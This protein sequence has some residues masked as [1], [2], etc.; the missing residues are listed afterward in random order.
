MCLQCTCDCEG[1][2]PGVVV[3]NVV[4]QLR[5]TVKCRVEC[6]DVQFANDSLFL[7]DSSFYSRINTRST[8]DSGDVRLPTSVCHILYAC[9]QNRSSSRQHREEKDKLKN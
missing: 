6:S 9:R 7:N 2:I 4:Q 5:L 3:A 8:R 1:P